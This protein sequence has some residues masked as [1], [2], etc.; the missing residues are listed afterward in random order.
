[1]LVAFRR[2][3]LLSLDDC[4]YALQE[5]IPHLTRAS[6]HRCFKRHGI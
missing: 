2:K 5:R 4:L 6:L 3:T 1:M